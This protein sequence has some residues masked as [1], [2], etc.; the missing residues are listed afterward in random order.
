MRHARVE[1]AVLRVLVT[2]EPFGSMEPVKW[3]FVASGRASSEG[4][5][6]E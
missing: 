5:R 4:R 1:A 3:K 2:E 6:K